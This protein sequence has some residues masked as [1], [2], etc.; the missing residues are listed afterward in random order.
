MYI[1]IYIYNFKSINNV[2]DAKMLLKPN[3]FNKMFRFFYSES[4]IYNFI[5]T[6]FSTITIFNDFLQYITNNKFSIGI[7]H[8]HIQ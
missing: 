6:I 1:Y 7:F 2:L 3:L 8:T 4:L 5:I